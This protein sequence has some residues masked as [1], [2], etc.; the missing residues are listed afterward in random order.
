M[1]T[2]WSF[3]KRFLQK[4]WKEML[5]ALITYT[6]TFGK[7]SRKDILVPRTNQGNTFHRYY[8]LF[9]LEEL[10]KLMKFAGLTTEKLV[11]LDEKGE[12]SKDWKTSRSSFL[13]AKKCP[14]I[15]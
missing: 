7:H 9:G 15:E 3:S 11:Y 6:V 2:N 14:I 4:Y 12:E 1:M 10:E 5:K 8:H 13:V